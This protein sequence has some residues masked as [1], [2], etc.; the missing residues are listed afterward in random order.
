MRAKVIEPC[1]ATLSIFRPSIERLIPDAPIGW[2]PCRMARASIQR[3]VVRS[4]MI[5]SVGYDS[6]TGVLEMEYC[7]GSLYRYFAV[8]RAIF[9][10]LIAAPSKGTFINNFIRDRYPCERIR[11]PG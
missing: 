1:R 5:A 11:S 8:P 6:I 4:S 3:F 7:N 10:R 9:D 2:H